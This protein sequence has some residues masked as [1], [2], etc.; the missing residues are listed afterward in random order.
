MLD[1]PEHPCIPVPGDELGI[2]WGLLERG[3]SAGAWVEAGLASAKT[4][5][6]PKRARRASACGAGR[7]DAANLSSEAEEGVD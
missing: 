7:F 5:L 6:L 2:P 3:G 1:R 4:C